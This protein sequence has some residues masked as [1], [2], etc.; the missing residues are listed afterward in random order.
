MLRYTDLIPVVNEKNL[1]GTEEIERVLFG[2]F[3]CSFD[4]S[5]NEIHRYGSRRPVVLVGT[6]IPNTAGSVCSLHNRRRKPGWTLIFTIRT[7]GPARFVSGDHVVNWF[8]DARAE[9]HD[10]FDLIVPDEIVQALR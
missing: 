4:T 6:N 8:E 5:Q 1:P 7:E 3:D 10:L 2:R 9:I